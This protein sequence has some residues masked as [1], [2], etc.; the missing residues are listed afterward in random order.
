MTKR[1]SRSLAAL[2]LALVAWPLF[3][4]DAK[5]KL[6]VLRG[7]ATAKL[8]G[9]AH[10]EVPVGYAFLDGK[11]TR[12]LMK[13]SGEPVSGRELGFLRPTNAHWSVIFEFDDIGYVKDAEKEKLDADKLLKSIK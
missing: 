10:I 6:D 12:A 8:G 3:A 9:V 7:P 11:T 1:N 2:A 4:Q 5:P 13:A